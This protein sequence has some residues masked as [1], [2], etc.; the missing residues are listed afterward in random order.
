MSKVTY[1]T[2]GVPSLLQHLY[3]RDMAATALELL[4]VDPYQR[5]ISLLMGYPVSMN[6]QQAVEDWIAEY[7]LDYAHFVDFNDELMPALHQY[8]TSLRLDMMLALPGTDM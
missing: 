6:N 8:L 7:V 1:I 2:N 5:S 3:I 4:N